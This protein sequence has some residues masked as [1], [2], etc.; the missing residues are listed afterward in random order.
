MAKFIE[1]PED[2]EL[3]NLDNILNCG[4]GERESRLYKD[5]LYYIIIFNIDCLNIRFE[6]LFNSKQ[7]RDQTFDKIKLSK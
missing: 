7:L 4:K 6:W 5:K 1:H 3:V 2:K